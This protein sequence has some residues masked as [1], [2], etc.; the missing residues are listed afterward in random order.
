[1]NKKGFT[2]IELLATIVILALV[3]TLGGYAVIT[4]INK[5]KEENYNVLVKNI[6]SAAETYYLECKYD[7]SASSNGITCS[8][9]VSLGDLVRY[10][11]L[12]SNDSTVNSNKLLNPKN[13]ENISGCK[14]EITYSNKKV[15]IIKRDDNANCPTY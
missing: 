11:Y 1:M 3:S 12:A 10:G 5:S 6:K 7:T 8:N 14:I 13:N 2:L 4:T 9:T 15:T